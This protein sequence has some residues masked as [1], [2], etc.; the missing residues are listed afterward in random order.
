V[1]T[2]I[3]ES[4]ADKYICF[5]G[6]DAPLTHFETDAGTG[7]SIVVIK[8]SFGNAFV[9]FLTSNYQDIYIIDPRYVN[10][11]GKPDLNLIQF[12][13]EQRVDDILFLNYPFPMNATA[14]CE[15]LER[16]TGA[17]TVGN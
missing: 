14:W 16:L 9:P 15:M 5:I 6:G 17:V 11:K 3:P 12:A 8:D 4:H 13:K 1:A 10:K 2:S 7:R